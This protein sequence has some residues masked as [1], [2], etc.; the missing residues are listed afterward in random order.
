MPAIPASDH[1]TVF[2]VWLQRRGISYAEAGRALGISRQRVH[3]LATESTN[4]SL[5]LVAKIERWTSLVDKKEPIQASSWPA[6][7]VI[8]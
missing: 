6:Y 1:L 2:G 3:L 7:S 4:P 5:A 8:V